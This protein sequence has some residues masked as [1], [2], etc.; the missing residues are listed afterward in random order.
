MMALVIFVPFVVQESTTKGTKDTKNTVTGPK[1]TEIDCQNWLAC[2][3]G[4][5]KPCKANQ[6]QIKCEPNA[7][8]TQTNWTL[9]WSRSWWQAPC[10][11][12][13]SEMTCVDGRVG[14]VGN[15]RAD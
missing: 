10:S 14:A 1:V 7:N 13:I 5:C 2:V 9:M 8:Q 3:Q 12:R 4:G 6:T 15:E 11:L